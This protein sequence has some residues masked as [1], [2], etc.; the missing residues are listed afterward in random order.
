MGNRGRILL[1]RAKMSP[2]GWNRRQLNELYLAYG[3]IIVARTS[4]DQAIHPDYP[5]LLQLRATLT[6]ASGDIHPDYVRTAVKMISLLQEM[7]KN[8]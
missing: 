1:E 5:K 3:F 8:K 7:R 4:H 2:G 6:R